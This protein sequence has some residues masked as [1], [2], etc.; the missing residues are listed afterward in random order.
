MADRYRVPGTIG[1][2]DVNGWSTTSGGA[3]GASIPTSAD[4]VIFDVN[5]TGTVSATGTMD[6]ESF[7]MVP[8][9]AG[10]LAFSSGTMNCYGSYS[11]IDSQVATFAGALNLLAT[12]PSTLDLDGQSV[13]QTITINGVGADYT[14]EGNI[15]QPVGNRVTIV[16]GILRLN[17]Y[18]YTG[19]L[20]EANTGNPTEFHG[21]SGTI[22]L[23]GTGGSLDYALDLSGCE[24]VDLSQTNIVVNGTTKTSTTGNKLFY[25][26]SANPTVKSFQVLDTGVGQIQ[27]RS[28][29]TFDD[30]YINS[31][32]RSLLFAQSQTQTFTKDNQVIGGD[33][34]IPTK[35]ALVSGTDPAIINFTGAGQL[36]F[37]NCTIQ[38]ITASAANKVVAYGCVNKGNNTNIFF[39]ARVP[40]FTQSTAITQARTASAARGA[41]AAR[42][43]VAVPT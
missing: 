6:M 43:A 42:S 37:R 25:F 39:E 24:V 9:Y 13:S 32:G 5:S 31:T 23:I 3:S 38:Y 4:D 12:G 33:F 19:R 20:I 22:K 40:T 28:A 14:C 15:V 26:G 10:T 29:T 8:G 41:T 35:V 2:A 34:P 7:T 16:Q 17:G 1:W 30:F 18:N 36:Q 11:I 27:I 21:G